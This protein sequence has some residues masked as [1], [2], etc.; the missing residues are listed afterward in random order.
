MIYPYPVLYI[1]N[2]QCDSVGTRLNY[3][4]LDEAIQCI[5]SGVPLSKSWKSK[6]E[7]RK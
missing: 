6:I 2:Y 7:K 1:L 3:E 5:C 4:V